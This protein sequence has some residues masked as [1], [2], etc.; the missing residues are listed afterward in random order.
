MAWV[1]VIGAIEVDTYAQTS[2]EAK[3]IIET[4]IRHLPKVHGGEGPV[5]ISYCLKEGSNV[6]SNTDEFGRFS[7]L[8]DGSYFETFEDQTKAI[9]TLYGDLRHNDFEETK[10]DVSRLLARLA[11][12][13]DVYNCCVRVTDSF[14][15]ECIF[16]NRNDWLGEIYGG[17]EDS[18][19]PEVVRKHNDDKEE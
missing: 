17:V 19:I 8:Y 12:R 4:V 14:K 1:Y 16:T 2:A 6:S 5:K 10:R 13:L 15:N 9:I 3:Y 7:N 18:W 11:K